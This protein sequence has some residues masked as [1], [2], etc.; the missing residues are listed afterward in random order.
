M[1]QETT[2][3]NTEKTRVLLVEDDKDLN[4]LINYSLNN[5]G[6]E[7]YSAFDGASGI[8]MAKQHLPHLI[9]LDLMLPDVNGARVC[10]ILKKNNATSST[11]VIMI[12]GKTDIHSKL[13]SFHLGADRYLTKPFEV[14]TLMDEIRKALVQRKLSETVRDYHDRCGDE[15]RDFGVFNTDPDKCL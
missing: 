1:T 7:A 5:S 15:E 14:E 13:D 11:P 6:Y 10:E 2:T 8:D 12:S 3:E 9:V 4:W